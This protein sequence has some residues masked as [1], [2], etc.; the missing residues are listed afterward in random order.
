MSDVEQLERETE[1]T[2]SQLSETLDELRASITPGRLVD[3]ISERLSEGAPAEFTRNLKE[4]VVGNPLP[5]AIIGASL[6]WL[7]LGPR[8]R[9]GTNQ[10]RARGASGL[11]ADGNA[12]SGAF[13]ADRTGRADGLGATMN[14]A[15]D[16]A[17]DAASRAGDSMRDAAGAIS[18]SASQAAQGVRETAGSMADAASRTASSISESTRSAGQRTLQ[19]GSTFLDFCREQPLL[20]AGLG[21][22]VGALMGALM[23]ATETEDRLMGETSDRMKEQARDL[24]SE[25]VGAAKDMAKETAKDMGERVLE[26]TRS[27]ADKPGREREA[28]AEDA[29]LTSAK[30]DH[31]SIVPDEHHSPDG[32]WRQP[33]KVEEA[34]VYAPAVHGTDHH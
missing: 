16:T 34:P 18:Q 1:Q 8:V 28:S 32:A 4:Q 23:P 30:P 22:A 27:D 7:M 33:V 10:G 29:A 17:K 11:S 13:S 24:A 9:S 12:G 20:L 6:A 26:T 5:L 31:P 21:V 14:R 15:T 3:Q 2:R 19:T 25:Q